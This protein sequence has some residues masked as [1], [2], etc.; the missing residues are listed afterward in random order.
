LN[1]MASG[2]RADGQL[3]FN[4]R[5]IQLLRCALNLVSG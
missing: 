4:T 1:A 3:L 2:P 5:A